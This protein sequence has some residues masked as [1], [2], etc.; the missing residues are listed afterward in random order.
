MVARR[1]KAILS[2][3]KGA[4]LVRK[5]TFGV[6]RRFHSGMRFSRHH[7]GAHDSML[8]RRRSR[9]CTKH[10]C[11]CDYMDLPSTAEDA[12]RSMGPDLL[13]TPMIEHEIHA[14]HLTGHAP[15]P[16]LQL[17]PPSFWQAITPSELRLV[18]H[19]AGLTTSLCQRGYSSS[20]VWVPRMP[21]YVSSKSSV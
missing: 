21:E 12:P 18:H 2:R 20:T 3:G 13:L 11:R 17:V 15:F 4:K 9:N 8:T 16:E 1:G 19:I 5:G 7:L 10:N 6:M 14:W